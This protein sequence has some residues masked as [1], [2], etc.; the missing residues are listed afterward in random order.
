MAPGHTKF[1]P[2]HIIYLTSYLLEKSKVI[3]VVQ[4]LNCAV[5]QTLRTG[6][7]QAELEIPL[8]LDSLC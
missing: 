8:R 6:A 5:K 1:Q 4:C 7:F 3:K 2:L